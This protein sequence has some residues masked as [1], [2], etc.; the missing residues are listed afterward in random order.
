MD[1]PGPNLAAGEN[2]LRPAGGVAVAVGEPVLAVLVGQIL[3]QQHLKRLHP[4]RSQIAQFLAGLNQGGI[5]DALDLASQRGAFHHH[6]YF[7][8]A[9][10]GVELCH[11]V[12]RDRRRYRHAMLAT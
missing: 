3:L 12:D 1:G 11:G 7:D 5:L 2:D 4:P 6:R 10:D 9:D 8:F